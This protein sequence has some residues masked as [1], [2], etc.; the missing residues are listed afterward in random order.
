[1]FSEGYIGVSKNPKNRW[2]QHQKYNGNRHLKNAISKYGWDE[3]VKEI[4]IEASKEYCF[5]LE[6]K[7]RP[8]RQ[9]GWNIAEGGSNPPVTQPRGANYISPLKGVSKPTPW[10]FGRKVSDREKLLASE[11]KKVKV[12]FNNIV[13]AS[14]TDLANFLD[15]KLSTLANRI[16]RNSQKWGYEVVVK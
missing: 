2:E 14:F 7:I 9:T 1:M 12:K 15:L 10:M 6:A 8:L 13:Y 4:I 16:Y 3:L 11:R 5:D